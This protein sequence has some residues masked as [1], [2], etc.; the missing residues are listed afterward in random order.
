MM[1][2]SNEAFEALYGGIENT[3]E[4]K[5][6]CCTCKWNT[7]GCPFCSVQDVLLGQDDKGEGIIAYCKDFILDK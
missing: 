7:I 2:L 4:V 1:T 5:D 3:G 6:Y